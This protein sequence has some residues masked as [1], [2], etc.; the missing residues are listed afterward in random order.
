MMNV[1]VINVLPHEPD[2]RFMSDQPRPP[3][4]WDTADGEWVGIYNN[5][6]PNKL[7][8][9]VLRYT[10]AFSY[11]VWQPDYRADKMYH[12]QFENGL[13]HRLFPAERIPEWY[14]I[15][16]RWQLHSPALVQYL[17]TY[18][19]KNQ[20][21][22]NL[23]GD[24]SV[25]NAAIMAD[26]QDLPILQTFRGTLRLPKTVM[27]KP[28]LNVLAAFTY[29][30]KHRQAQRLMQN[31]DF[32]TYQNSLYQKELRE[33][34]DGPTAKLTSGCDFSFW[35][36]QDQTTCRKELEI[37]LG[38]PVFLV[39]SLLKPLKQIDQVIRV[40]KELE[41]SHDFL[42]IV[43][44]HGEDQYEHY[45]QDLAQPL[46]AKDKARFVGYISGE[47]ARHYYNSAD[48]FINSS[49]TEGGPVSAM[50]ALACETPVFSTD[51][52]NV[53]ERMRDHGAG[54]L[55]GVNDYAQWKQKLA[56]FMDGAPVKKFDRAE[57]EAHYDWQ[58][59]AAKFS[60]IYRSLGQQYYPHTASLKRKQ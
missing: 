56:R 36:T 49:T 7:G 4:S 13:V 34:F 2:Y 20:V 48:L 39:S 9:Q 25:L 26:G 5:E 23:N 12:H 33:L 50:K 57:A 16:R 40:F 46:I 22:V 18:R 30:I 17:A 31:V 52:G 21:V 29:F 6:I 11:E 27:F 47:Q 10:D 24:I 37:P 54:I 43:S 45:L 41:A 32:V 60:E 44:G 28:R 8:N 38:K 1:K 55:V 42:L 58:K 15:K 19:Q 3:V 51:I 35:H 14:G 59:I 53:A